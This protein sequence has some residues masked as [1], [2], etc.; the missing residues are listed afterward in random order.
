MRRRT[1]ARAINTAGEEREDDEG[2]GKGKGKGKGLSFGFGD[3]QEPEEEFVRRKSALSQ[4]VALG[5]SRERREQ[6]SAEDL[7]ALQSIT[8]KQVQGPDEIVEAEDGATVEVEDRVVERRE[9]EDR[10]EDQGA[11]DAWEQGQM[12]KAGQSV[13]QPLVF[14]PLP[15]PAEAV[16][17]LNGVME[18]LRMDKSGAEGRL[19]ELMAEQEELS[20]REQAL[21][22]SLDNASREY[23]RLEGEIKGDRGSVD[24]LG[25]EI[26]GG[27]GSVDE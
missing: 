2:K 27:R 24:G 17:R 22:A 25:G 9:V 20:R 15:T 11:L 12:R 23:E 3:E 7:A 26:K 4:R 21:Q 6:Y 10:E 16:A 18:Q 8:L 1:K 13:Q 19:A 5:R 14:P